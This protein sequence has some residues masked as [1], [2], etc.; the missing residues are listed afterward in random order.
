CSRP[1]T[2]ITSSFQYLE[3]VFA[4]SNAISTPSLRSLR[5]R[6]A[7]ERELGEV[8]WAIVV[9]RRLLLNRLSALVMWCCLK[10]FSTADCRES[11]M[12]SEGAVSRFDTV[13]SNLRSAI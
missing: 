4:L 12:V 8:K 10:V 7:A 1:L 13:V 6:S 3:D 11:K 9:A 2:N 5:M